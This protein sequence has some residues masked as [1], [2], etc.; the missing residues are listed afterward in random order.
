MSKRNLSSRY[1]AVSH[2]KDVSSYQRT[3]ADVKANG[4]ANEKANGVGS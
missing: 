3:A 4:K 2:I 1:D